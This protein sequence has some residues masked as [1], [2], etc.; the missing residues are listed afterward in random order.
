MTPPD[1]L[2]AKLSKPNLARSLSA[3]L[4]ET[5]LGRGNRR[6]HIAAQLPAFV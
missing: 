1:G 5:G 2:V 6:T 4:L 3:K